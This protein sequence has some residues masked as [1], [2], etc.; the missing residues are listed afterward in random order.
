[1]E[2]DLQEIHTA[3]RSFA[4]TGG[5]VAH[6]WFRHAGLHVDA[7]ADNSPVTIA[8]RSAEQAI[9]AAITHRFPGH[10]ILG[11][12]DGGTL[13][14]EGPLWIID[15]IDGTKTFIRGVPLYTTLIAFLQDG[16][17]QAGVIYAPATGEMVSAYYGGGTWD[18]NNKRCTVAADVELEEAWFGTTDPTDLFR[19]HQSFTT[20]MLRDS[21]ATRTWADGYGY[22]LL[23]RG[24]LHIMAD[25]ILA[26]WD[27]A[28]L[29][30]VVREAGGVFSDFSGKTPPLGDSALATASVSLHQA[31]IARLQSSDRIHS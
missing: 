12:E 26:P 27:I 19:R 21:G 7:K 2:I 14:S 18:E 11:E 22:L 16:V 23:A 10:P 1:V 20:A 4:L 31:C 29:A 24:D 13:Q 17:P 6:K 30:L 5:A 8:D 3:A 28:A 9:R 15:P 25:P